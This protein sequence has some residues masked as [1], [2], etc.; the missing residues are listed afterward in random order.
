MSTKQDRLRYLFKQVCKINKK[1]N[2]NKFNIVDDYMDIKAYPTDTMYYLTEDSYYADLSSKIGAII[3]KPAGIYYVNSDGNVELIFSGADIKED[4]YDSLNYVKNKNR[5]VH[6]YGAP[7]DGAMTLKTI[8]Q[9]DN[10]A[11]LYGNST[12]SGDA[13]LI[14]TPASYYDDGFGINV[15]NKDIAT[16][17][18]DNYDGDIIDLTTDGSVI[19]LFELKP[20]GK[21]TIIVDGSDI[22]II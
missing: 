15:V 2:I 12:G 20:L 14:L 16:V 18:I 22:L 9:S 4:W 21:I 10:D 17:Y 7:D 13:K 5:I 3:P 11:L 8:T 6:F 1:L 19:N